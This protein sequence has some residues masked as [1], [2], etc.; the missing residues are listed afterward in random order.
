[1][2]IRALHGKEEGFGG[3]W[4]T[5][6]YMENDRT[7]QHIKEKKTSTIDHTWSKTPRKGKRHCKNITTLLLLA[8]TTCSYTRFIDTIADVLFKTLGIYERGSIVL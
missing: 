7:I 8:T 3:S 4:G 5:D 1:M 2:G 6:T